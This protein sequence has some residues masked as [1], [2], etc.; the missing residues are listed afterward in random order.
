MVGSDDETRAVYD[1]RAADYA[2]MGREAGL[3]PIEQAFLDRVGP[4]GR[5]LDFGCGPGRTAAAMRDAG[6]PVD[7]LD[8]SPEMAKLAKDKFGLDVTVAPFDSLTAKA[9]YDGVWASFS[10]L[11]VP[12]A[13][14][15]PLLTAIHQALKPGG[16]LHVSVKLG[17]GEARDSIGRFYAYYTDAELT[18]LLEAAGFT[19]TE[20]DFGTSPGLSGDRAPWIALAAHA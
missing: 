8:A 16:Q 17:M 20:R 1:A 5:I 12:K 19:V 13:D 9:L 14:L 7:A 15:P 4:G 3:E 6:H 18:A 10:L 11:H 2:K